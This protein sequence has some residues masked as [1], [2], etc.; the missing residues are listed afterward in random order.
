MQRGYM[1]VCVMSV[2]A[3]RAVVSGDAVREWQVAY[4]I[5]TGGRRRYCACYYVCVDPPSPGV[6][7][8]NDAGA[9]LL[10]LRLNLSSSPP[11]DSCRL[12][13]RSAA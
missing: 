13:R 5:Y 7:I 2:S 3:L 11:S 9:R 4:Y 6:S 8:S 1:Y 10:L 12:R